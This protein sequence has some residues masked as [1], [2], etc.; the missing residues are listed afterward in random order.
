MSTETLQNYSIPQPNPKAFLSSLNNEKVGREVCITYVKDKDE[1]YVPYKGILVYK[2]KSPHPAKGFP[3]VEAITA[4]NIIKKLILISRHHVIFTLFRDKNKL[5]TSFNEVSMKALIP[6]IGPQETHILQDIYL[7][8]TAYNT[9]MA[10]YIFLSIL[11]IKQNIAMDTATIIA[12]IFEYDDA[13]RYRI[14]DLA[15]STNFAQ[16][17]R[18][19]QKELLRLNELFKQRC[20]DVLYVKVNWVLK[21]LLLLFILPKVRK[22]FISIIPYIKGM[23]YDE[24]DLFWVHTR[25]DNYNFLGLTPE[26]RHVKVTMPEAVK[27]YG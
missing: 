17:S 26:E 4:I 1:E 6:N 13:Y 5:L 7:C 10:L 23:Q 8:P 18:N 15:S 2:G 19:P 25:G 21:P 27:I 3:T 9:K 12:H 24:D 22:A 16:L 11:G 14:Q 20:T